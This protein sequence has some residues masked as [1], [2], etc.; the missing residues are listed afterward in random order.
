MFGQD[1]LA[2]RR[3]QS[4]ASVVQSF[5]EAGEEGLCGFVETADGPVVEVEGCH[6]QQ[7]VDGSFRNGSVEATGELLFYSGFSPDRTGRSCRSSGTRHSTLLNRAQ[8]PHL[9]QEAGPIDLVEG[10]LQVHGQEAPL[11]VV[12]VILEPSSDGVDDALT[13]ACGSEPELRWVKVSCHV[14]GNDGQQGFH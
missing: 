3:V 4:E 12:V 6:V 8:M 13:T 1:V 5:L 11:L 2:L 9:V 14:F 7:T 10:V